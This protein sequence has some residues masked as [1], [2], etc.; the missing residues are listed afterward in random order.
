M[1]KLFL[2]TVSMS[3]TTYFTNMEGVYLMIHMMTGLD[4]SH[5]KL[6]KKASSEQ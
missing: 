5:E 6:R 2:E 3:E 1:V 4:P